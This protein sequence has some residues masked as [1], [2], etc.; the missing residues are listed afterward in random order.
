MH[1][2]DPHQRCRSPTPGFCSPTSDIRPGGQTGPV[3]ATPASAGTPLHALVPVKGGPGAKSRLGDDGPRWA[4]AF[5]TDVLEALVASQRIDVVTLVT[6]DT[7]AARLARSHAVGVHDDHGMSLND[8]LADA[9]ARLSPDTP[10]LV[11]LGDV[12]C[13][14]A[15]TVDALLDG[16]PPQRWFTADTE[17]IGSTML[18]SP[19]GRDLAPCFGVR[20]RA[21]H[22]LS[23]AVELPSARDAHHAPVHRDVDT[24]VDLWDAARIGV[25]PNTTA[26]IAALGIPS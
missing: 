21:A 1:P 3:S 18:Y 12:P 8:A 10:V 19:M 25:G 6:S 14:S 2:D 5:L 7:V 11:V 17:G 22:R 9:A 4:Q 16:A 13:I 26:L 15:D 20:S 23:G 24:P